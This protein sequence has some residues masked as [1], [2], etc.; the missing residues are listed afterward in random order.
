MVR[1]F[2][3]LQQLA[4]LVDIFNKLNEL[5][6]SMQGRSIA[7]LTA[8]NKVAAVKLKLVSWY[9]LVQQHK[10]GCFNVVN[11]YLKE[12]GKTVSRCKTWYN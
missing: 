5:R 3:W 6:L 7:V 9:H 2:P 12:E 4:F 8:D 11:E 1:V 10:I